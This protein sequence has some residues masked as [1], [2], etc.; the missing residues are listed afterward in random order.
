MGEEHSVICFRK[1]DSGCCV[2][3]TEEKGDVTGT[4]TAGPGPHQNDCRG[5]GE[6]PALKAAGNDQ[7][8]APDHGSGPC[9]ILPKGAVALRSRDPGSASVAWVQCQAPPGTGA[10][11]T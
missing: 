5:A 1:D 6:M 4:R 11:H 8:Q 2:E 7:G 9:V 10:T 3:N